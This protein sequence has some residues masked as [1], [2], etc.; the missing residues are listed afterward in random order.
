MIF[1]VTATDLLNSTCSPALH[2]TQKDL[3]MS[4]V[5]EGIAACGGLNNK[6]GEK[7]F[8][9]VQKIG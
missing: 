8:I 7:K 5:F 1:S 9:L 3:A 2:C 6:E 4:R